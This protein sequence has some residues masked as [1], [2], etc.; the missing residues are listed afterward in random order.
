MTNRNVIVVDFCFDVVVYCF[1]LN[2]YLFIFN[3]EKISLVSCTMWLI[4]IDM[5]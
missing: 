4:I 3:V 2:Y 1:V 5:N